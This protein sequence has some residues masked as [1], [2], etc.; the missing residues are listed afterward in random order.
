LFALYFPFSHMH[1]HNHMYTQERTTAKGVPTKRAF[2]PCVV[3]RCWTRNSTRCNK[4][5]HTRK[6][7][8]KTN[9]RIHIHACLYTHTYMQM[10]SKKGRRTH[11]HTHVRTHTYTHLHVDA[12][13][14]RYIHIYQNER[15]GN[16]YR[17]SPPGW[18]S[19][20]FD[21]HLYE[22]LMPSTVQQEIERCGHGM[23]INTTRTCSCD[24]QSQQLP[25]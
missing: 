3:S 4:R 19:A 25:H 13:T 8:T 2:V 10:Y 21:C 14:H 6:H 24:G 9:A 7:K 22:E 12:D 1:T 23:Y 11:A 20:P 18:L 15:T 16:R 17:R 5:T